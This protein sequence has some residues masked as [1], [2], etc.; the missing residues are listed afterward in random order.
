MWKWI[1]RVVAEALLVIEGGATGGC[2]VGVV[3]ATRILQVLSAISHCASTS[4]DQRL[5][6]LDGSNCTS[7]G[8]AWSIDCTLAQKPSCTS[9]DGLPTCG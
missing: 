4:S 9:D 8:M 2:G 1:A 6:R 5:H 3:A 7:G